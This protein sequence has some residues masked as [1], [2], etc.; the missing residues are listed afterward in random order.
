M[1]SVNETTVTKKKN[2]FKDVKQSMFILCILVA[3]IILFYCIASIF[4]SVGYDT[5]QQAQ[6]AE[7]RITEVIGNNYQPL[8][9]L[10]DPGHG[11]EDPGAVANNLLE[12]DLNLQVAG[13]LY[14]LL[15]MSG[16]NVVMT[17]KTDVAL[18]G[19]GEEYSKKFYDVRNRL[20]LIESY[21]NCVY[22]GIHMNK[23]PMEDVKGLQTFFSGNNPLS[24]KFA[25]CVQ[26]KTK[27]LNTENKREIKP[28][29]NTIFILNR[30]QVPAVLVECGFLSNQDDAANLSKSDYQDKLAFTI[31]CGVTDFLSSKEK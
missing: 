5:F 30:A 14:E 3:F 19:E 20:K 13:K 29:Q 28:E 16:Y 11:G 12:K 23:F 31:F 15:S 8:T 10:I 4:T 2:Y 25:L 17:R 21:D 24:Q 9:I 26:N 1:K 22:I 18:Y 6:K 7:D 27:L